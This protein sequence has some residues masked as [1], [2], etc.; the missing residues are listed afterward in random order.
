MTTMHAVAAAPASS[1]RRPHL[2]ALCG[3]PFSG[4]S[5]LAR[6]LASRL[7]LVHVEVDQI[8]RERGVDLAGEPI[9]RDAWIAAY[10]EAHHRLET[11]LA[12]NRSVVH[13]ATSF[14]RV[15]RHRLRRIAAQHGAGFTLV[16]V[17][18][19]VAEALVRRARNRRT[20]E[21]G[22][23]RDEDFAQVVADWQEPDAEEAA[24]RYNPAVPVADLVRQVTARMDQ[25]QQSQE[26]HR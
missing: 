17:D 3:L 1:G 15:Q 24:I 18:V 16:H 25:P 22:D 9:S 19:S 20:G 10:R 4:K 11:L 26:N 7:G 2:I 14:R 5:T 13:D 6:A 12:A 23:V 21:R 8:L